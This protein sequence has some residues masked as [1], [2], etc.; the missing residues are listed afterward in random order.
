MRD[1]DINI[2]DIKS[3]TIVWHSFQW[4]ETQCFFKQDE[5]LVGIENEKY[6]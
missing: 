6:F 4:S 1:K 5:N 3:D 2:W